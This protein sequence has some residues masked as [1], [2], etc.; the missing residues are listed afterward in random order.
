MFSFVLA[1]MK[2]IGMKFQLHLINHIHVIGLHFNVVNPYQYPTITLLFF[3]LD[4]NSVHLAADNNIL[5]HRLQRGPF[6]I[7]K[8]ETNIFCD[9]RIFN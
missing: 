2:F 7:V 6:V 9:K 1:V 3:L 8:W 4:W 5:L